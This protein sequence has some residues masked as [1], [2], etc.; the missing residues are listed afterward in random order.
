MCVANQLARCIHVDRHQTRQG[1]APLIVRLRYSRYN[2]PQ[3]QTEFHV[4][5]EE[6]D[7]PLVKTCRRT[8]QLHP[9]RHQYPPSMAPRCGGVAETRK[10]PLNEGAS[11]I[12]LVPYSFTAVRQHHGTH[13]R[14]SLPT[15]DLVHE[16]AVDDTGAIF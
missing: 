3:F 9:H 14:Q 11:F 1:T 7:G 13:Y 12:E 8:R 10:A 2:R 6:L 4:A 15:L 5:K 16:Q